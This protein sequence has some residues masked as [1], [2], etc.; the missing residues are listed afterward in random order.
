MKTNFSAHIM[1]VFTEMDTTYDEMKN[2][3]FD[4]YKGELSEGMTKKEAEDQLRAFSRKI[5]GLGENPSKRDVKR[6]YRDN[7]RHFFDIIEEVVDWTVTTGLKESEWFDALVN[8]RNLADGDENL[9]Y[10]DGE[11]VILSV[12]RMGKRHHDTVLQRLGRGKTFSIETDL[13]G[14]AVGAAIDRYVLGLEDWSKLVDAITK[15]FAVKVQEVIFA[16]IQ[17]AYKKLPVQT[18]FVDAGAISV[19]NKTK[20]DTILNNVSTANDGAPVVIMGL[21]NDLQQFDNLIP[22]EW[23]ADS[24]KEEVAAE[25]RIGHY[26]R[27]QFVE[28]PDRFVKGKPGESFYKDHILYFFATGDNKLVDMVD[29]GETLVDEIT[30]RG[31]ANGRI[32]DLMK[33][34]VQREFGAAVRLGRFFGRWEITQD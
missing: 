30:E 12:A 20:I 25:G 7:G 11:E 31:E 19:A 9:F 1:N 23:I 27:Y 3:M 15:A 5:F 16:E 4:L 8:Y 29:V 6:A 17:E 26:G 32:D 10:Q 13:Y 34:E 14:A 22:I 28:I 18:G 24:Q 33:Y 21:Y 2:L